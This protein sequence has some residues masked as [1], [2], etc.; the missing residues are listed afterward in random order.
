MKID[1]QY[2]FPNFLYMTE[3]KFEYVKN[4]QNSLV[5][6]KKHELKTDLS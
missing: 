2:K 1:T 4:I 6:K 3:G 5:G